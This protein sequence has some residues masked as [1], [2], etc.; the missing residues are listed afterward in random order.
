MRLGPSPWAAA[1]ADVSS[2][3]ATAIAKCMTAPFARKS[4]CQTAR[5]SPDS[6]ISAVVRPS[7]DA[8]QWPPRSDVDSGSPLTVAGPRR[9]RGSCPLTGFP[10]VAAVVAR[11]A[12]PITSLRV[13]P[14]HLDGGA[15]AD[16]VLVDDHAAAEHGLKERLAQHVLDRSDRHGLARP[17]EEQSV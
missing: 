8:S 3:K 6:W 1:D 10:D 9:I 11:S 15:P 5:R 16:R 4:G 13:G 17:H 14:D 7:R 12:R 2:S